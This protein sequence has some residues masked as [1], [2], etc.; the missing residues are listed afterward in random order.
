MDSWIFPLTILPGIGLIIM[1]T[2]NWSVALAGEIERLLEDPDCSRAIVK[3]KIRQ[4][5]LLNTALVALYVAAA[6]CALG[7]SWELPPLTLRDPLNGRW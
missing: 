5:G 3:R 2:T 6:L 4:L 1:S 7:A